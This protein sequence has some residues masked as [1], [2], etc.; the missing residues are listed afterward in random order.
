MTTTTVKMTVAAKR[1]TRRK[2]VTILMKKTILKGMM[3][4]VRLVRV[5]GCA[6]R[7][8]LREVPDHDRPQSARHRRNR[9]SHRRYFITHV[10]YFDHPF[11]MTHARRMI[12]RIRTVIWTNLC[13]ANA[14]AARMTTKSC[15]ATTWPT[16]TVGS[17]RIACAC[18]SSESREGNGTATSV[19][20][21]ATCHPNLRRDAREKIST[22]T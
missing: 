4:D 6:P 9:P 19:P 8:R 10:D 5:V 1:K 3:E 14:T 16:A 22:K 15:S 21:R 7:L 20:T 12:H 18:P 11:T 13:A 2:K 17:I